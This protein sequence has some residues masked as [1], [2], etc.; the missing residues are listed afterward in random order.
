MT[1]S[2]HTHRS[3]TLELENNQVDNKRNIT[4]VSLWGKS[5]LFHSQLKLVLEADSKSTLI[6]WA[7]TMGS[8]VLDTSVFIIP[9]PPTALWER[10]RVC[11]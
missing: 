11:S 7:L 3:W 8:Q 9:F 10:G 5:T 6:C 1:P 2:H 4:T